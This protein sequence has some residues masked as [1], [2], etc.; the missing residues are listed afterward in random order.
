[1]ASVTKA[2]HY[3]SNESFV[4]FALH[5][6]KFY[7][8]HFNVLIK[9]F[10]RCVLAKV[11]FHFYICEVHVCTM[12]RSFRNCLFEGRQLTKAKLPICCRF[13]METSC[14]Y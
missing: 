13:Y 9:W 10:N 7:C 6:V 5:F 8:Y 1:M 3:V 4:C 14:F 11:K 12:M 2:W